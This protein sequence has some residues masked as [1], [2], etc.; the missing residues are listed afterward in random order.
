MTEDLASALRD[1]YSVAPQVTGGS[2]TILADTPAAVAVANTYTRDLGGFTVSKTMS[3]TGAALAP[4][5]F[6]F[7]YTCGDVTGEVTVTDGETATVP[8]VPTGECTITEADASVA[9]ADLTTTFAVDGVPVAGSPATITVAADATVQV[10]ATNEYTLHL[11]TFSIAKTATANDGADFTARAFTFDY[12]CTNPVTGQDVT[13]TLT[14]PADGVAVASGLELPVGAECVVTEDTVA[15]QVTDYSLAAPAPQTA[16][17]EADGDAVVLEFT[18]S[19]VRDTGTFSVAKTATADDGADLTGRE[20]TFGYECVDPVAGKVSGT[21]TAGGDGTAT[22]S[23]VDL[24]VG[25]TCVVTED[26]AAA[27]VEGYTQVA[28]APVSLTIGG[29]TAVASFTNSY[30]NIPAPTPTPTPTPAPSPTPTPT[31]PPTAPPAPLPVTGAGVVP[32][33]GGSALL[34]AAG[35]GL[36]LARRRSS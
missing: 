23:G 16:T 15:A 1:G 17:I 18:N 13:G 3:G 32:L 36:L 24:S 19:Y 22:A 2:F 14:V 35:A 10:N 29:E 21:V 28:S 7:A 30:T 25:T 4:G 9:N 26:A 31:V 20:Y 6:T 5:E 8:G 34:L 12:A 33:V 27:Q 11:G